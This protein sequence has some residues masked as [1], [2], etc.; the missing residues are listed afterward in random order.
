M[1]FGVALIVAVCVAAALVAVACMF[2]DW[3][4]R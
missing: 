4:R 2:S 1:A 3:S